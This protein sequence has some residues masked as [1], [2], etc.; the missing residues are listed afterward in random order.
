M[1]RTADRKPK[2]KPVHSNPVTIPAV[3][4]HLL[5]IEGESYGQALRANI[6]TRTKNKVTAECGSVYPALSHLE[7]SGFIEEVDAVRDGPG[8]T[9]K[10]YRITKMG[11]AKA[12]HN[13][14]VIEQLFG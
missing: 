2:H 14:A 8:R 12:A 1:A 3:V 7:Q 5:D 6:R 11:R 9:R 10:V 4:L 13:R